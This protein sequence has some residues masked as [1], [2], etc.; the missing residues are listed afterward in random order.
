MSNVEPIMAALRRQ[1]Q[2][3]RG[4]WADVSRKS[5]VPY[6]TLTKIAQGK[7][8]DPRVSTVQLLV[9]YFAS[10][11][12]PDDSAIEHRHGEPTALES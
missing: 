12:T 5:G 1:L 10:A 9:D 6:H 2:L 8:A 4:R 7:V 11:T 3:T